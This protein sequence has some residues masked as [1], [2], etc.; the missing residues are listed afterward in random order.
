MKKYPFMV[1]PNAL[2]VA[3][4]PQF[5]EAV[6]KTPLKNIGTR[7]TWI[8]FDGIEKTDLRICEIGV[9]GNFAKKEDQNNLLNIME[10][11]AERNISVVNTASDPH[12]STAD[13]RSS[14][15]FYRDAAACAKEKSLRFTLE[16]YGALSRTAE[17][18][19]RF[20]EKVDHES[21]EICY[22]TANV[23][24]FAPELKTGDDLTN[25]FRKLKGHVGYMRLKD[26]DPEAKEIM[27]LGK[28]KVDFPA[29]FN[30]LEEWSF[31]GFVGLDLET[32]RA[33]TLNTLAAHEEELHRS[34]E[35]LESLDVIK[36][37]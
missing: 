15:D 11:A 23:W 13:Q 25:D 5:L 24:R 37:D 8:P 21:F 32:T 16:T 19:L 1:C 28:G 29:I 9:C 4:Y 14:A 2:P 31:D 27:V 17:E 22:D 12:L 20:L 33:C 34:L 30:L 7:P 10:M 35:Y 18:C 36:Q 3:D 26:F 6:S